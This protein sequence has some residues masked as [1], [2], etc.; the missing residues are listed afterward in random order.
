MVVTMLKYA[1]VVTFL[2]PLLIVSGLFLIFLP[3]V[4][5][6][7][8]SVRVIEERDS[9]PV[10]VS[11]MANSSINL[12]L[13]KVKYNDII[14]ITVNSSSRILIKV[15]HENSKFQLAKIVGKNI[16][17]ILQADKSGSYIVIII[18]RRNATAEI[19]G[20]ISSLT[21][22]EREV[23]NVTIIYPFVIPGIATSVL[24]I[25]LSIVTIIRYHK[26]KRFKNTVKLLF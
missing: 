8:T 7:Q 4:V 10:N 3:Q 23:E 12:G 18:N 25:A 6:K 11:L 26:E 14:N 16:N 21:I 22:K 17:K 20:I 5:K 15:F 9:I 1:T 13:L 2:I 24:G 19:S